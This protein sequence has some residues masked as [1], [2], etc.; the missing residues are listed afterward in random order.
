MTIGYL[1][2]AFAFAALVF[3]A[4]KTISRARARRSHADLT[5]QLKSV[6]LESF[7]N[8]TDPTEEQYLRDRLP[9]A[10]FRMIQRERLRAAIEYVGGV[11]HN[12][13]ILLNL[14][15][16][17][18]QNRDPLIADAGRDLVDEALRLRLYSILTISKLWVRFLFPDTGFQPSPIVDRYQH[19]TEGAVRLGRLQY[20]DRGSLLSR[21]L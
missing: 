4:W 15:Q 1:I 13:G 14:G 19:V 9:P 5:Q 6:D 8:L 7:R 3:F 16:I 17:A 12:A 18:R 2:I 20:P 10:E 11:S 21:A